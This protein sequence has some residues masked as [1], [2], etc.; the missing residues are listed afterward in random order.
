[1]RSS[2]FIRVATIALTLVAFAGLA[3][4]AASDPYDAVV[5]AKAVASGRHAHATALVLARKLRARYDTV[6]VKVAADP[7]QRVLEAGWAMTCHWYGSTG[8]NSG[9][10]SGRTPLSVPVDLQ[11]GTCSLVADATLS[12]RGRVTVTVVAH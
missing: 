2:P 12:E 4:A 8:R 3:G 11:P 9:E 10:K 7:P 5:L 1:M 6:T